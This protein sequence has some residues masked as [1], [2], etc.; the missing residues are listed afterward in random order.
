MEKAAAADVTSDH[1]DGTDGTSG[2]SGMSGGKKA[3]IAFGV[4]AA[5]AVVGLGALVYKRRQENIRRSRYGYN[6]RMMEMI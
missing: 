6:A 4:I 2:G 5:V 1:D 3:G